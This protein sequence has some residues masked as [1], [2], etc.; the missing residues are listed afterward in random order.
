MLHDKRTYWFRFFQRKLNFLY[1][2]QTDGRKGGW[3]SPFL[4]SKG[5]PLPPCLHLFTL[6]TPFTL[7]Y[8]SP[9]HCSHLVASVYLVNPFT[10][11]TDP[12]CHHAYIFVSSV[13]PVYPLTLHSNLPLQ[14]LCL[15]PCIGF[16]VCFQRIFAPHNNAIKWGGKE[17]KYSIL[18]S[19]C[20]IRIQS[21]PH[22]RSAFC[23]KEI[24]HI[25]GLTLHPGYKLLQLIL[26]GTIQKLTL[27]PKRPYIRGPY[28][29]APLYSHSGTAGR[30]TSGLKHVNVI[31]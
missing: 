16:S 11:H 8:S 14:V 19:V 9:Q 12:P 2:R 26:I 24:D 10:F 15:I 21:R 30:F 4:S 18:F 3:N 13:Y 1:T 28:K 29:R 27:H 31:I 5:R 7:F 17:N 23:P 6:F 22:V 25:S 20:L